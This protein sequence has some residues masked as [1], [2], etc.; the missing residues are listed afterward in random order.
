M[1]QVP[2][3]VIYFSIFLRQKNSSGQNSYA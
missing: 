2:V 3:S 1:S